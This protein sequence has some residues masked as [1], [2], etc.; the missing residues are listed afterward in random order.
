MESHDKLARPLVVEVVLELRFAPRHPL[1]D[2]LNALRDR[3]GDKYPHMEWASY[4]GVEFTLP[5][6]DQLAAGELPSVAQ[7]QEEP[8][9]P[10][11]RLKNSEG[12]VVQLGE[13]IVTINCTAYQ[14]F[15]LFFSEAMRILGVHGELARP[16]GYLRIGLR[17]INLAPLG[18]PRQMFTW[19]LPAPTIEVPGLML[20]IRESFQQLLV[21]FGDLG[22]QRIVVG[23]PQLVGDRQGI[24]LDIDHFTDLGEL[25][26]P[27]VAALEKWVGQ[28]HSCIW[29]TFV[30]A[31]NPDFYE[32]LRHD[33]TP[34]Q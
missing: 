31:L 19:A 21:R 7:V 25:A 15:S 27:D 6:S 14:G 22:F 1:D 17:Y 26:S 11:V 30:G 18:D 5:N 10:K 32:E 3:I 13:G 34:S 16:E 2:Y 29:A 12:M 24:V 33:H 28:A 23:A 4:S 9:F 8:H 20:G